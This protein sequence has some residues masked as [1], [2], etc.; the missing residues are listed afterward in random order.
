MKYCKNCDQNVKPIKQFSNDWFLINCFWIVGSGVYLL[1]FIFVKNKTCPICNS[2][3]EHKHSIAQINQGGEF[4]QVKQ[5]S[6]Q[7]KFNYWCEKLNESTT[8]MN[9]DNIESPRRK[10]GQTT[11]IGI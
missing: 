7:D 5:I 8:K 2:N 1:Y 10:V 3:F 4:E 6:N 11:Y 9:T